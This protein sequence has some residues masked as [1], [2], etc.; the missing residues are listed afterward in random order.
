MRG[1]ARRPPFAARSEPPAPATRVRRSGAVLALPDRRQA[2]RTG[3]DALGA[4][5]LL[6]VEGLRVEFP[7]AGRIVRAADAVS[8]T[9]G[10]GEVVGL[11]GE[12]GCG[13]TATALGLVRLVPPPGRVVD[14]AVRLEGTEILSLSEREIRRYRGAGIAYVPQEP[15]AALNPVLKV[16]TQIVDVIRAHRHV[17][18]SEAWAEAVE[19]LRRVGIPDPERRAREYP[20]QFSGGMK[21]RALIALALAARPKVLV[22]DEPTTALDVTL[23]AGILDLIRSLVEEGRLLGVLLVTHDLGVVAALCDRVLVMYAGRIVERAGV[24]DLFTDPRHPYTRALLA[25]V[26]RPEG[27]RG[28]LAAIPGQVPDLADLPP[29]CAF[30]PRCPLAQERCRERVPDLEP[31]GGERAVACLLAEPVGAGEGR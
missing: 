29:G 13:K 19:A 7:R 26:P 25:S 14:G 24:R 16:G 17:P 27:R 9:V 12:S 22:A 18:R 11:V 21:Q 10:R 6:A 20:H 1:R 23:Q 31:A 3:T 15:G 2:R 5:P 8:F 4:E 28:R 30:H